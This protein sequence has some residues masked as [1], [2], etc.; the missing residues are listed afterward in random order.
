MKVRPGNNNGGRRDV[1][2]GGIESRRRQILRRLGAITGLSFLGGTSAL[3]DGCGGGGGDDSSGPN[4]QLGSGPNPQLGAHSSAFRL[5]GVDT[6]L[7]ST[8]S[9]STR[10][11]GS[12]MLACVGR[13]DKTLFASRAPTDNKGNV[14]TQLDI[15][16]PYTA[17]PTSGTALYGVA[18]TA[19]GPSHI[20]S[21]ANATNTNQATPDEITLAVVEVINGGVIKDVQ[22]NEVTL[23]SGNPLT[24]NSVVT[25]GPATLVAFWWGDGAFGPHTATPDNGFT[26]IDSVLLIGNLVQCA[27]ATKNVAAAGSYNVTWTARSEVGTPQEGPQGAQMWLVAVQKA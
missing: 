23:I 16:R 9:M 7:L 12:T 4:P 3:L 6:S 15:T 26:V 24:S 21:A 11:S 25:T 1:V 20:V 22:W 13:G 18:A 19:G 5:L 2:S 10:A 27:V 17:F 14:Y 8:A